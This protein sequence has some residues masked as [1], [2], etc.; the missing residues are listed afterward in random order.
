MFTPGAGESP[1]S[2]TKATVLRLLPKEGAEYQYHVQV[3]ADGPARRVWEN[4][5]QLV[6]TA[7]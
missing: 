4:Q 6:D 2:V 5:L 3:E 7:S 1:Q